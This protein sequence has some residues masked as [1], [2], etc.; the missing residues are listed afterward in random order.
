M[1][2]P[3]QDP[4]VPDFVN[5]L[6][7]IE[8]YHEIEEVM[9]SPDFVYDGAPERI[10]FLEDTLLGS[11]GARHAELKRL[12]A[13]RMSRQAWAYYEL[14]LI[15]P[16][17]QTAIAELSKQ[18]GTNRHL[19]FV[20]LIQVILTRI[21]AQVTGVDGVDTP[22]RTAQFRNWV[23]ELSAA[24]TASYSS[25][26]NPEGLI[27]NGRRALQ[28]LVDHFLQASL[29]RRAEMARRHKAGE[30]EADALPRDMLMALCLADDI[31]RDDD[32]V[33]IP[34]VWRQCALFL[35][36]SIK[37]TSHTLP[38]VMVH[39]DE[40]FS[41]HPEDFDKR[42]DTEW[43]HRAV[44]ESIRL[45][46]TAPARFRRAAKNV[47]LSTGRTVRQG[48]M[49]ALH[50]PIANVDETIFGADPRCFDPN[51]DVIQGVQPW[52]MSFGLG[53][54]LCLGRNLVTGI[55]NKGDEKHGTHG[56]AVR[57]LKALF[58]RGVELDPETPPV[59]QSDNLHDSWERVPIVLTNA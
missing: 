26:T 12:F 11:E 13:P 43:L 55:Q 28:D 32:R 41:E 27:A 53:P 42:L 50:A 21:A 1:P 52:G 19:D 3:V 2:T 9:K 18:N 40:W 35:T 56:T 7:R 22:E 44:A 57:L 15:E 29:E 47:T 45:H 25:A 49:V 23:L 4:R 37:T 30:I 58:E 59:R 20:K 38:H 8:A 5:D 17:I 34:Y 24:T 6:Q 51:R 48:E 39:L 46:Q 31:Q 10:I 14:H 36:A 33:K 54:H 16:V